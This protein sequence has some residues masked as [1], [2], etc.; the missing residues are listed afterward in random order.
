MRPG[1]ILIESLLM[2]ISLVIPT[3]HSESYI[4]TTIREIERYVDESSHDFEIVFVDDGSLDGTFERVKVLALASSLNMKCIQLFM[5]RGQFHAIMAGIEQARGD[6]IVTLDDDLEYHPGQVD[7]LIET[8]EKSAGRLDVV[9][10]VPKDEKRSIHRQFGSWLKNEM[11]TIMFN[12]PRHLRPGCFRMMSAEFAKK[13]LEFGTANPII[14]P[15]IFKATRRI[16]NVTVEHSPGLRTSN[17]SL[18]KLI[19]TFL[20][21]IQG[22][23]EFPLRYISMS[24]LGLSAFSIMMAGYYM[25]RHLTGFPRPIKQLGWTSLIVTIT[26]FS[27]AI[28]FT[29]GF[30]G[31]YIYKIIEEVNKTPNY[32]IRSQV[33]NRDDTD[34]AS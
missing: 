1:C 32:Q 33:D 34:S 31:Q 4:E 27:G 7:R 17:Y 16:A 24:G 12:K 13:L 6:Y 8:F 9:I 2:F 30:I 22:F 23:S 20:S 10:G 26:F 18:G 5:N 14:G 25:M 19:T 21:I 28:L 11:N 29:L 3:Y 15:L